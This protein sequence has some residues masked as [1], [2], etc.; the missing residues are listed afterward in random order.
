MTSS[1]P[2]L[3]AALCCALL[4]PATALAGPLDGSAGYDGGFKIRNADGTA[5]LKIGGRV[6]ALFDVEAPDGGDTE[7]RFSIPRAR[8]KLSGKGPWAGMG[9]YIQ[10]DMGKGN[11]SLKDAAAD[12]RLWG[13]PYLRVGQF[14][15]PF[16]RQQMSSSSKQALVDRAIT[17]KAFDADRDIG[18][19]LHNNYMK[20][21]EFEWVVGVFNGT[22][23]KGA[24]AGSAT[25]DPTTGEGSASGK[26]SNVP[27]TFRPSIVARVGY[28][29]Q[30]IKSYDEVDFKGGAARFAIAASL[31]LDLDVDGGDDSQLL[32]GL[33]AMLKAHH[34]TGTLAAFVSTAQDGSGF[35]DQSLAQIGGYVQASHLVA[36]RYLPALR[37]AL[38]DPDG[39]DNTRM[40]I[41]GG[42]AVLI[43]KHNLKWSTDV[44]MH[45]TGSDQDDIVARTMLQAGF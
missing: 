16:D 10:I 34:F 37:F 9:W 4:F 7:A 39:D 29:G 2:L 23:V 3:R 31:R 21:P 43:F 25:V 33:D 18:L 27:D 22:S 15:R 12:V 8:I 35:G 13:G 5:E 20:S 26:F 38:V 42:V 17:T 14:K 11:V 45:R 40:E 41:A 6:Q 36:G 32:A 1:R 28:N 19:A 30:G 44:A 24:F